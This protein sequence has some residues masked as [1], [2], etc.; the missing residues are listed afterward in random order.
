MK[1]YFRAKGIVEDMVK[2]NTTS[3]F[4]TDITLLWW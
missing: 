1:N 3:I 2:V 4:L